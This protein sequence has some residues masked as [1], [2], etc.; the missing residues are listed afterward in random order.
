MI[1][2]SWWQCYS[3]LGKFKNL[4]QQKLKI[5]SMENNLTEFA[6]KN[7]YRIWKG[8]TGNLY[9]KKGGNGRKGITILFENI[10]K[11]LK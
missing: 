3:R 4:T 1:F 8:I 5:K 11:K 6:K 10:K 2:T 7:G 9:L